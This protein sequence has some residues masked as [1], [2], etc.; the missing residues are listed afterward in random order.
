MHRR[1][2]VLSKAPRV[3]WLV[4]CAALSTSVLADGA[5]QGGSRVPVAAS[6]E[7]SGFATVLD[8][9]PLPY[10]DAP[11][12][13]DR[14]QLDPATA[15]R[16]ELAANP[17]EDAR[18]A[19]MALDSR[20]AAAEGHHY[21]GMRI[22]RDPAPRFAF[23][24]ASDAAATLARHSGDPRFVARE[25]GRPAE[26]LQPFTEAWNARFAPYRLGVG[27]MDAFNGVVRF[28]MEVDEAT[29]RA[30]AEAQG[31]QLPA[32]VVLV[33]TPP[34]APTALPSAIAPLVRLLP[35]HDRVP[36]AT[37]LASLSGRVILRDGCFRL[38]GQGGGGES[39]L[40]MFDRD[41]ALVVDEA[42]YLA[43]QA[44]G[45]DRPPARVGERM[46]WAGPRGIDA[47]DAGLQALRAACGAGPVVSVGTPASAH[48][49]R[50]RPWV[51]DAL[52]QARGMTR[53]QAWDALRRCWALADAAR[54]DAH[55]LPGLPARCDVPS[56][57][58]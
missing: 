3:R 34:P 41:V 50:V 18:R 2:P 53:Q 36:A 47:R 12:A 44:R 32:A 29:F 43:L 10:A 25:G 21:I 11:P 28:T 42:G 26:E 5:G 15:L 4:L 27:Q 33:F 46:T 45:S 6:L 35:R 7:P 22:V 13:S 24:F 14:E 31:W 38:T 54:Q 58:L 39:P 37:T 49:A 16:R 30:I 55:A 8:A 48:H 9:P 51:I 57:Y 40:V 56:A 52:A 17:P 19:A 20:L 23:H 1:P